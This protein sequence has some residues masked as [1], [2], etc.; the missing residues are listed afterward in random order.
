MIDKLHFIQNNIQFIFSLSN[1][2]F[3]M[4]IP[5]LLIFF[6]DSST[7]C[8]ALQLLEPIILKLGAQNTIIHLETILLTLYEI[9]NDKMKDYL[10]SYDCFSLL[11]KYLGLD[12]IFHLFPYL[13]EAIRISNSVTEKA[14]HTI[15]YLGFVFVF[16]L[17]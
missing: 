9:E 1:D 16:F 4:L 17:F 6:K 10:L 12:F 14:E 5:Y 11:Q 13:F 15:K 8:Q 7:Q 3:E 2:A